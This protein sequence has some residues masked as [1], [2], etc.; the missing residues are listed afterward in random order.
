MQGVRFNQEPQRKGMAA[1]T[2]PKQSLNH[3]LQLHWSW[4]LQTAIGGLVFLARL[5][6]S[7]C[8][9]SSSVFFFFS[10]FLSC[11]NLSS[12]THFHFV[13]KLPQTAIQQNK[14]LPLCTANVIC[15]VLSIGMVLLSCRIAFEC[16][17]SIV[18]AECI[19]GYCLGVHSQVKHYQQWAW[20]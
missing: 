7:D 1:E 16:C 6:P 15:T 19:V 18:T 3:C 10:S 9:F 14:Y 17:L 20:L 4:K 11:I 2:L 12:I 5:K 13:E 8:F